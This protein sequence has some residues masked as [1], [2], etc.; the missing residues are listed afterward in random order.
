MK[1]SLAANA[2]T[3]DAPPW[4]ELKREE[5]SPDAGEDPPRAAPV[6][7]AVLTAIVLSAQRGPRRFPPG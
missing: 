1:A 3:A 5:V 2:G 7:E 4:H 6:R